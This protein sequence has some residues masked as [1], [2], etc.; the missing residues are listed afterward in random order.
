M[1][2][3]SLR[4]FIR[5]PLSLAFPSLT[6]SQHAGHRYGVENNADPGVIPHELKGILNG[7]TQMEEMLCSLASPCFIMWVSNGGQYKARGNV[8]TFSQDVSTLCTVL[9]HLPEEL[10]VLIVRKTDSQT[11][12]SYKDFR[13]YKSK[14][15][16]LLCYL[17]QHNPSYRDITIR[18]PQDSNLPDDDTVFSRLPRL[19]T[20]RDPESSPSTHASAHSPTDDTGEPDFECDE[21]AQEINSF[22]PSLSPLPSEQDAISSA[23][24]LS[25][26]TPS[27]AGP[28]PWPPTGPALSEYTTRNLFTMAFPTLFPLGVADPSED[29]PRKL[30]LH[31]WVKH[32][33]RYRDSRFA[34]H[35]RFRFFALNLIF[36]HRAMQRGKYMFSR[37]ISHHCMTIAQLKTSLSAHD[38]PQLAA[39]IARC[40]KTVKATRPY[41]N[42]EGG[43]LRDMIAQIGTPTFFYTLSMADMSWPDLHNLMPEDPTAPGLSPSQA[44]QVRY[45]NLTGNPHIVASYLMRKHHL[46]M[47]T[48]LQHLDLTDNARV[49]DFWFRVEWQARGS[50]SFA[51]CFSLHPTL[52]PLLRTH[53]RFSMARERPPSRHYRLEQPHGPCSPRRVLF[54]LR[55]CLQPGPCPPARCN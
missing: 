40:L 4:A 31:E 35:P 42:M 20:H 45:R 36:H 41:W 55:D 24:H 28:L 3:R 34:T 12:P 2:A 51:Y 19:P 17:Q 53:S 43:K 7:I 29:R 54:P 25:G 22:V 49:S 32:L 44:S 27:H 10:D 33:M 14:V 50:G 21:L 5:A 6:S 16:A 47:D 52:T 37:N 9:P 8:I 23:L 18:P 30:E 39:D 46:L 15:Y 48:V 1:L 38:G 11:T 26:L 13:V